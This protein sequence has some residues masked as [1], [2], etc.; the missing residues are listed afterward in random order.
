MPLFYVK[1]RKNIDICNYLPIYYPAICRGWRTFSVP[2]LIRSKCSISATPGGTKKKPRLAIRKS[3]R[4]L[5]HSSFITFTFSSSVSSSIPMMLEG[6][7]IPVSIVI[8]SPAAIHPKRM[9]HCLTIIYTMKGYPIN[10][11][12]IVIGCKG[13]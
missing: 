3:V 6:T 8:S 9:K 1:I 5:T 10:T 11:L 12:I 13:I 4:P 2:S 7:F